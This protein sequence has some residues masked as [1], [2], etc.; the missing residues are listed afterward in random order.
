[1]PDL[2][3]DPIVTITH[4]NA[5]RRKHEPVAMVSTI[6]DLESKEIGCRADVAETTLENPIARFAL[7][8]ALRAE[9]VSD[10]QQLKID[11]LT[12]K[13]TISEAMTVIRKIEAQIRILE[14]DRRRS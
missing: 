1:M 14:H 3:L 12:A 2:D 13:D 10:L 8:L 9:P 7:G 6:A 5:Y 11:L 4:S